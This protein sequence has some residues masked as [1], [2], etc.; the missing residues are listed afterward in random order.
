[1]AFQ[2]L[3]VLYRYTRATHQVRKHLSPKLH[4]VGVGPVLTPPSLTLVEEL[5]RFGGGEISKDLGDG[6]ITHIVVSAGDL[7]RL[8]AI[9]ESIQ[10]YFY[11]TGYIFYS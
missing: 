6:E 9:R 7:T 1:M 10:W 3:C 8:R 4:S 11:P 5:L 2:G